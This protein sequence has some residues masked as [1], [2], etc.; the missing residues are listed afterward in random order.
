MTTSKLSPEP[1]IRSA[2]INDAAALARLSG[3]LGY[4]ST[5]EET[6]RRLLDVNGNREHAVYIA[7]A[8]GVLIGW[9]HV[10]I[11]H[12]LLAD[13]P[14]EVA[15]LVIDENHRGRGIGRILMR[16]A[17]LWTR[18]HGCNTVTLRSNVIRSHAHG[19]YEGL[20][21]EVTKT[22]KVFCKRSI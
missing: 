15:G 19:F 9:I 3:Q 6:A 13:T 11:V 14:V 16:Q 7:E 1:A 22:Q 4:S 12:S 21:Y 10:F 2:T 17:E 5:P 8:D 20:G 18:E